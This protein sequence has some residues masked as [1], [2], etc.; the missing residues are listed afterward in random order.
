MLISSNVHVRRMVE[1]WGESL[2]ECMQVKEGLVPLLKKIRGHGTPPD[3]SVLQGT[4]D[5]K[6]QADLCNSIAKELGFDLNKGRL[7]VSVHPFTGGGW[8]VLFL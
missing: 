5:S 2:G 1:S 6:S 3:T 7:D 8:S 4:F